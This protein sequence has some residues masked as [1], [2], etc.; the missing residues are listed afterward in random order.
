MRK[1]KSLVGFALLLSVFIGHSCAD[2]IE[3]N[4]ENIKIVL[5]TPQDS[6]VTDQISIRF[7]WDSVTGAEHYHLQ[8]GSP[9]L[10][11][12]GNFFLDTII[13]SDNL[14]YALTNG[15]YEW[16]VAGMN[17]GGKTP[18]SKRSFTIDKQTLISSYILGPSYGY[19]GPAPIILKWKRFSPA[20]GDSLYIF[21]D[22]SLTNKMVDI[23]TKDTIFNFYGAPGKYFWYLRSMDNI[24][25]TSIGTI[26]SKF[27]IN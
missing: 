15:S 26:Y 14:I 18:Y 27:I 24:G 17:N 25:N 8:I 4:I 5:K 10:S 21:S 3:P 1:Y 16:Q 11:H 6:L 19:T 23:Y 2:I 12:N 9:S 20:T 13:R 7:S 22:S